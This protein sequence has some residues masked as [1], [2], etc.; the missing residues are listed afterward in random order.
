[1]KPGTSCLLRLLLPMIATAAMGQG[2]VPKPPAAASPVP[3]TSVSQLNLMLS[4]VEQASQA[5]LADLSKLRMDRW[6]TDSATKRNAEGDAQSVQRNLQ[7]ALPEIVGQLRSAPESLPVTFKLYRNLDALYEVFAS[8]V[9]S[10][11]AFGSRDEYQSLQNDL[12]GLQRARRSFADRMDSLSNSKEQE[13][14]QLRAQVHDLRA[15]TTAAPPP[16]TKVV[17]DDTEP[18]KPARKKPS[19]SKQK[20]AATSSTPASGTPTT[21][22]PAPAQPQPH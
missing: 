9:E 17:V 11:G 21:P 4:E 13:V 1:M 20:A 8:V 16:P 5:M 12:S 18:A 7:S 10:A 2:T 15:A 3:Y 6:K 14:M 19:K 22:Q